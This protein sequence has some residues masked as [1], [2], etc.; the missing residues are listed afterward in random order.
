MGHLDIV[1][2]AH[3]LF[4]E[5]IVGVAQNSGKTPLLPVETR[6]DLARAALAGM[7]GVRVDAVLGLLVDFCR[8]AGAVGVVKGLRGGADFDAEVPMAHMNRHLSGLETVF[9]V[10]DSALAHVASSLVK[11]VAK[12]GG[13]IDDLVPT[14]VA[15]IVLAAIAAKNVGG[16]R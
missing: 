16:Q 13:P 4:D 9:V 5:V 8:D 3:S 1:R 12:H 15:P 11:D 2:R 14:G 10:G 7:P 6:V